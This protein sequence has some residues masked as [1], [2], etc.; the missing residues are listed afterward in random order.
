MANTHTIIILFNNIILIIAV[1]PIGIKI[2]GKNKDIFGKPRFL[3]D[4]PENIE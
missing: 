3:Q 4:P 1:P 2:T